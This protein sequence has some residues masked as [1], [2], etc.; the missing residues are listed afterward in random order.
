M[1]SAN[2]DGVTTAVSS[3]QH[4]VNVV[5]MGECD[6][7]HKSAFQWSEKLEKRNKSTSHIFIIF[8]IISSICLNANKLLNSPK[9]WCK[10]WCLFLQLLM[11]I[12]TKNTQENAKRVVSKRVLPIQKNAFT[13]SPMFPWQKSDT[14]SHLWAIPI[15]L[16]INV[17]VVINKV[18]CLQHDTTY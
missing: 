7:Q 6:E 13:Q 11:N 12:T 4:C 10:K 1:R 3:I 14:D 16:E 18:K 2:T 15:K 9:N 17:L 8:G 5:L